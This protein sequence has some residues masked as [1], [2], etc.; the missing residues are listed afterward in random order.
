MPKFDPSTNVV[1]GI[2]LGGT[3][4]KLGCFDRHGEQLAILTQATPQPSTP[5]AVIE[6]IVAAIAQIDPQAQAQAIGIG[7]PGPADPTGRIARLAINLSGWQN[8]PLA[9]RLEAAT[10]RPTVIANDANCAGLGEAWNGA[11]QG[12]PN[13][14]MLTLGTGVGGAIILNHQLYTGPQGLAGELGLITL[15]PNGPPCNSGNQGSLEQYASTPDGARSRHLGRTGRRRGSGCVGVLGGLWSY[16]SG[17]T[18]Q[19]C[20]Y[21]DSRSYY[22]WGWD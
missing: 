6:T 17:R 13:L 18:G 22:S 20:L 12:I 8:V 16:P 15:D 1:L 11:G 21:S 2:D 10:Q 19:H 3:A 9:D 14:V 7:T 4:I 5:E